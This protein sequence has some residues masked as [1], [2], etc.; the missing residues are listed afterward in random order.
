VAAV[1]TLAVT[2]IRWGETASHNISR[3]L[4]QE[5]IKQ[6]LKKDYALAARRLLDPSGH[7]VVIPAR[8]ISIRARPSQNMLALTA[9][10]PL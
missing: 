5:Q 8:G 3:S 7:T 2:K 1:K 9:H 6:P 4:A 10:W